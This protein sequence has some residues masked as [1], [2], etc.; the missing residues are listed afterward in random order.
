VPRALSQSERKSLRS[1]EH[2]KRAEQVRQ[3]LDLLRAV[4]GGVDELE[5]MRAEGQALRAR[6]AY[7]EG[8]VDRE[9][10]L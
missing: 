6:V 8:I 1:G 5:A 3:A 9:L 2:R 7:L 10:G 4:P